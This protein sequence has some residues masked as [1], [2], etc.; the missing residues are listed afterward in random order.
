MLRIDSAIVPVCYN[1][2]GDRIIKNHYQVQETP[3]NGLKE[4]CASNC[5]IK[6]IDVSCFS[7]LEHLDELDLSLNNL[8]NLESNTFEH[9]KSLKFLG[10]DECGLRDL[11]E[12]I[13]SDLDQLEELRLNGNPLIRL[14]SNIF[15][16]LKSLRILLLFDLPSKIIIEDGL[17]D[18]LEKL[19]ELSLGFRFDED[20]DEPPQ[21]Q[22][23]NSLNSNVFSRLKSLIKLDMFDCNLR[24]IKK[25]WFSSF[26]KLE[27][28]DLSYNQIE[29][30][31]LTAFKNLK[32]LKKLTLDQNQITTFN[33]ESMSHDKFEQLM[34]DQVNKDIK[35]VF[36]EHF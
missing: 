4:L 2:D 27:D 6:S 18:S 33:G 5:N 30:L 19:E 25:E 7:K 20:D 1:N 34:K 14:S 13:F 12:D 36:I 15:D 24:S 9:L 11:P 23:I 8:V 22:S 16:N 29:I 21:S 32:E 10:L 26:N 35:I 17:F 3:F 28:L 31:E